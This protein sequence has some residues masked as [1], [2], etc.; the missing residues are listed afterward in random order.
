MLPCLVWSD[1]EKAF[2]HPPPRRAERSVISRVSYERASR[3]DG[4]AGPGRLDDGYKLTV[5]E[6]EKR[7]HYCFLRTHPPLPELVTAITE[8]GL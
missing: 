8:Y 2:Q 7:A 3:A 5:R 6:G 4:V 1:D